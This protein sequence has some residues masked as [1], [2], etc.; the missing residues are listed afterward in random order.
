[1]L[2]IPHVL[3]RLDQSLA[4]EALVAEEQRLMR[5]S[6]GIEL[7]ALA[8]TSQVPDMLQA[9]EDMRAPLYIVEGR[10]SRDIVKMLANLP[11]RLVSSKQAAFNQR[12]VHTL[13]SM[14][15]GLANL[16]SLAQSHTELA[17][18]VARQELELRQLRKQI[19]DLQSKLPSHAEQE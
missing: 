10:S 11:I 17:R 4:T 2:H 15:Q 7:P 18:V 9:L 1:M 5:E 3:Q 6:L 8:D 12:L 13:K 19:A 16:S 14:A